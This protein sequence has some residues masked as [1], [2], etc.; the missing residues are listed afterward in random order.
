[1]QEGP[2]RK[3]RFCAASW[4]RGSDVWDASGTRLGRLSDGYR[5]GGGRLR[6]RVADG[7]NTLALKVSDGS[8]HFETVFLFFL[9]VRKSD[10]LKWRRNP[11]SSN[12]N[13][14]ELDFSKSNSSIA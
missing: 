11:K 8:S 4:R 13:D 3:R 14:V 12:P 7:S 9:G 1:M 6:G 2:R 5:T 10:R